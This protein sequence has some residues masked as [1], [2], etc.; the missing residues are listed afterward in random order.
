MEQVKTVAT[1]VIELKRPS[2]VPTDWEDNVRMVAINESTEAGRSLAYS[3]CED[4]LSLYLL[5][6]D[7][8]HGVS[9]ESRWKLHV[10]LM[11]YVTAAHAL[12]GAVTT[13]G[14]DS[15]AIALW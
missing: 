3:F 15:D 5:D 13:I 8:M 12:R 1:T 14:A 2:L 6:G 11:T 10:D 4:P 7:D 9:D